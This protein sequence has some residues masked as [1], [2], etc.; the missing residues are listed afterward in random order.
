M[1]LV[2]RHGSHFTRVVAIFAHELGVPL[3]LRSI[4]DLGG[5]DPMPYGGHPALKLPTLLVGDVPLFGAENAC[6]K[7]VEVAG[8]AADPRIVF[9]ERITT[10]LGRSA[11]ELVVTAMMLQVQLVLGLRLAKLPAEN[12]FFRK[13]ELGLAGALA[14]LDA[15]LAAVRAGLPERDLSLFEVMLF[16]LVE[17][18]AFRPTMPAGPELLS[19]A[20][21][22][23]ARASATATPFLTGPEKGR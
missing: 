12:V 4:A 9:P 13:A 16:C 22:F 17:H 21:A 15:H 20:A 8:R 1:I 3:E 18:L 2:G 7:L 5:L 19:F 23:G 14:W 10:E 11:Q 6:R